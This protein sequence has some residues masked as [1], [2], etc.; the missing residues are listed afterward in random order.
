VWL[1]GSSTASI[2]AREIV[3][4]ANGILDLA[5]RELRE[6]TPE[7]FF[8]HV[9]PFAFHPRAPKPVRW[10]R[11]L[12]SASAPESANSRTSGSRNLRC[13]SVASIASASTGGSSIQSARLVLVVAV[14]RRTRWRGSS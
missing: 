14:R 9:L 2:N 11:F 8:G 10:L 7:F 6:H 3:P 12:D 4:L 13:G 1:R 5:T